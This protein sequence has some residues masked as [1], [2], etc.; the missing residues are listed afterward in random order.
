MGR[1][2]WAGYGPGCCGYGL[3]RAGIAHGLVR[4]VAHMAQSG[5]VMAQFG[6]GMAQVG[7]YWTG[8]EDVAGTGM[9]QNVADMA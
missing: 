2:A 9:V 7:G 4:V 1:P 5:Q 3:R 6:V 8:S